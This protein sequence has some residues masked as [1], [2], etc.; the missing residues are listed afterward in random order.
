MAPRPTDEE[1][2]Q[3]E[4]SAGVVALLGGSFDPPHVCHVLISLYA[5]Q[6]GVADEVWWVPCKR[7]AFDKRMAPFEDRLQMCATAT[8]WIPSVKVDPVERELTGPSY[9]LATVR[10]LRRRHPQRSFTWIV[11]SDVLPD[12]P[13]WHRWADLAQSLPFV[14]VRRGEGSAEAPAEGSFRWLPVRFPDVSSSKL[15]RDLAAG[16]SVTGWVDGAVEAYIDRRG[17]YS[18]WFSDEDR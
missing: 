7:H 4:P 1:K 3:A 6:T 5:M 2:R 16:G 8:R 12:L 15:R 13:R 17:L 11:G 14:V 9:T 10:E 18:S